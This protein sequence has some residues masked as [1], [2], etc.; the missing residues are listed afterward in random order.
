MSYAPQ[1]MFLVGNSTQRTSLSW[2]HDVWHGPVRFLA[3]VPSLLFT[4]TTPIENH[5]RPVPYGWPFPARLPGTW[6][7][8]SGIAMRGH[9]RRSSAIPRA[10]EHESALCSGRRE[11]DKE[12]PPSDTGG[13][14]HHLLAKANTFEQEVRLI[15]K[16]KENTMSP[17]ILLV[18]VLV[19]GACVYG[20]MTFRTNAERRAREKKR[21]QYHDRV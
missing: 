9:E 5:L 2:K 8:V 21:N 11:K 4:V 18:V 13:K 19:I 17:F 10:T 16:A 14:V 6:V 20:Y 12:E 15:T 1:T 3:F 7:R